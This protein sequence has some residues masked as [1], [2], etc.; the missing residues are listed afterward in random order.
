MNAKKS[1]PSDKTVKAR[2]SR[3]ISYEKP[4]SSWIHIIAVFF[5][6]TVSGYIPGHAKA[7]EADQN[8]SPQL[9]QET[10]TAG[11]SH[12][13]QHYI[14]EIDLAFLSHVGLANMAA[15]DP[16]VMIRIH[17]N[18][19]S[20][21][22]D[23]KKV[24]SLALPHSNNPEEWAQIIMQIIALGRD[25]SMDLRHA[26]L[27]EITTLIFNGM[28]NQLDPYS[29]YVPPEQARKQKIMREGFHGV[30]MRIRITDGH[31][32][33]VETIP[34]R[35]AQKSG[36]Q[37]GDRLISVDGQLLD[38]KKFHD[39]TGYLTGKA[40]SW[41]NIT[42]E[43]DGTLITM[44]MQ[45]QFIIAN[46]VFPQMRGNIG[47]LRISSFNKNTATDLQSA[48][49]KWKTA[50]ENRGI[51]GI[52]LDLRSN[53]GGLLKQAVHVAD[54]F[55]AGGVILT[56]RGRHPDSF[57]NFEANPNDLAMN[58]P[59]AV[60]IDHGSA[61]AAEITAAALQDQGRS[62]IIGGNS[63]GKGTVQNVIDL[64]NDAELMITWSRL[65]AP[66][67]YSFDQ[68]GVL[69]MVCTAA[70]TAVA[71]PKKQ[72]EQQTTVKPASPQLRAALNQ[73]RTGEKLAEEMLN[74][75]RNLCPRNQKMREATIQTA[76]T[77]LENPQ[78]Y[79]DALAPPYQHSQPHSWNQLSVR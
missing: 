26:G 7:D 39:V 55:L 73:W 58:L 67:G 42:I 25:H 13:T 21:S 49:R 47:Y 30:G 2:P 3:G 27:N 44:R 46:T 48:L 17:D 62:V 65:H 20:L 23:G 60:L 19:M 69:P 68:R 33:V 22:I 74:T 34:N 59:V 50:I 70:S 1:I 9:I 53:N 11:F 16:A 57:Q 14:E 56:T 75:L 12:I 36:I 77:I 5:L 15:L 71:T 4:R 6:I 8:V 64:P 31:I 40:G 18:Q 37:S 66:S 54:T 28:M 63:Y 72:Q 24:S 35:P 61:S 79:A 76:I 32:E 41:V 10:F 78:Q 52:I 43:R 51:T 38:N 45:R 29:R